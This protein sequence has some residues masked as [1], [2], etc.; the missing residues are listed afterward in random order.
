M[1]KKTTQLLSTV[2][3]L[4]HPFWPIAAF[5]T[6]AGTASGLATASLLAT[7]NN[8]LHSQAGLTT[9]LLW[10]FAG[11]FIVTLAGEIISDIGNTLIGQKII[12]NL[13]DEISAKILRAP[14]MEIEKFQVHRVLTTLNQDINVIS[15][16]TFSFSGFLIAVTVTLACFLYLLWLSPLM[17]LITLAAVALGTAVTAWARGRGIVGFSITRESEDQ[18][19][20]HYRAIIEGAKEFKMHRPRR[21]DMYQHKIQKTT[22]R[23]VDIF[24]RS[25]VLFCAA[26]AFGSAL[27]FFVIGIILLMQ[28]GAAAAQQATIGGFVL[29]LLYVRGPLTQ[30][31]R[32]DTHVCP[33]ADCHAAH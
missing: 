23:I 25:M 26:N 27:F 14:I 11:L 13:R 4:L 19:Q 3:R 15:G 29:V 31:H 9:H 1:S 6:A 5:A 17:F 32:S 30:N 20:K 8:A 21:I 24:L 16:F 33:G 12:A 10:L 22:L 18:L 7:I 2:V 28:T